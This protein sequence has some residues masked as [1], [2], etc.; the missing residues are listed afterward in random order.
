MILALL[1]RVAFAFWVNIVLLPRLRSQIVF[2]SDHAAATKKIDQSPGR[3]S[4]ETNRW[5]LNLPKGRDGGLN[6]K[7]FFQRSSVST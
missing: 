1:I 6:E 2:P 4:G 3:F 5:P 7:A